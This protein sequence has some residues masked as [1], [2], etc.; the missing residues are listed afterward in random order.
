ML[1]LLFMYLHH[2]SVGALANIRQV[3]VARGDLK[4]LATNRGTCCIVCFGHL[5][6]VTGRLLRMG[7]TLES[8][9]LTCFLERPLV[10]D[11]LGIHYNSTGFISLSVVTVLGMCHTLD[12]QSSPP[13]GEFMR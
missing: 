1:V 7:G 4:E 2:H 13:I 10:V 12:S 9:A 3:C 8:C 6:V 11:L 5:G